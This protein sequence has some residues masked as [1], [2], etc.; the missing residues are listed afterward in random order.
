[1]ALFNPERDSLI[2][3]PARTFEP[4]V[5]YEPSTGED[6]SP[7]EATEFTKVLRVEFKKVAC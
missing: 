5:I 1:M 7:S 4:D 3:D 6:V 2:K